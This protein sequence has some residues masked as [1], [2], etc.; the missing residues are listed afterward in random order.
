MNHQSMFD[1]GYRMLGAVAQ[2]WSR[3]MIWDGRWEGGSCL[4]TL[5]HPWR[6]HVNVWQNQH[7]IVKYNKVKIKIKK[8]IPFYTFTK[9]LGQRFDI[10]S[11]LS[12]RFISS[13]NHCCSSNRV[14]ASVIL[15]ESAFHLLSTSSNVSCS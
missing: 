10:F 13:I 12:P 7:S 6:I 2:G 4:G 5:V 9:T 8:K 3:E 15:S 14:P 11:F 1:A